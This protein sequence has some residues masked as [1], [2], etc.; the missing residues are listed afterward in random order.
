MNEDEPLPDIVAAYLNDVLDRSCPRKDIRFYTVKAAPDRHLIAVMLGEEMVFSLTVA[1]IS[2]L[3]DFQ[4]EQSVLN[5]V[6]ELL[7][8]CGYLG[9]S[10]EI[11]DTR[12]DTRHRK[13]TS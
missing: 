5:Y 12:D 1:Q 11:Q 9:G 2:L 6:Y 8:V 4:C 7:D 3:I 13:R 10:R